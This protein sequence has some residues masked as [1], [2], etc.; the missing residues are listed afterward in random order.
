MEQLK[1]L[2]RES[3]ENLEGFMETGAEGA[4]HSYDRGR[5]DTYLIVLGWINRIESEE[6]KP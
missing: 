4:Y 2:I 1:K 5:Y 3:L 6:I